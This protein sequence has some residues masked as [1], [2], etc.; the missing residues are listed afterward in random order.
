M[1]QGRSESAPLNPPPK[2]HW[3]RSK[4]PKWRWFGSISVT[5][6]CFTFFSDGSTFFIYWLTLVCSHKY[7]F[8]R[9]VEMVAQGGAPLLINHMAG[10][11]DE[12]YCGT[13]NMWSLIR[14]RRG[15]TYSSVTNYSLSHYK[16]E[17][18]RARNHGNIYLSTWGIIIVRCLFVWGFHFNN[19]SGSVTKMA[20]LMKKSGL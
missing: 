15:H 10:I 2:W 13:L 8:P 6:L 14:G 16:H 7:I 4:T 3:F 20:E 17:R 5:L 1:E 11:C 19:A 18:R 9:N 12:L